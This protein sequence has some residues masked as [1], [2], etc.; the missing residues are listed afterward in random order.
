MALYEVIP[1]DQTLALAIKGNN[2]EVDTLLNERGIKTL[3][4]R[5]YEVLIEG[6]TSLEEVYPLLSGI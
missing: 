5:A 6:T 2:H 3:A 1:I 4:T